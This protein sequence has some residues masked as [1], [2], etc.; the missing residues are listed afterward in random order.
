[1]NITTTDL[2]LVVVAFV[3]ATALYAAFLLWQRRLP[4]QP[5]GNSARA[6]MYLTRSATA[7]EYYGLRRKEIR[8]EVDTVRADLAAADPD[9]LDAMLGGFGPPRTLAAAMASELLRPSFLR[10]TIWFGGALLVSM[11]VTIIGADAF[12]GGFE[13]VA[14]PGDQASW[15]FAGSMADATMGSDARSSTISFGRLTL[16]VLPLVAF[17]AGLRLWRLARSRGRHARDQADA[18]MAT[19]STLPPSTR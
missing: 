16:L 2:L 3:A 12:L 6:T 4:G 19:E 14:E 9:D 11:T 18:Y 1:M 8:V 10:G 13:A 5:F 7:L 17:V 15:S